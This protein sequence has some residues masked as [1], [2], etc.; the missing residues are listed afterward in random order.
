MD[1]EPG[2]PQVYQILILGHL[3]DDWSEWFGN[4]VVTRSADGVTTLT[5]LLADQSALHGVLN[6]LRDLGLPIISLA[7]IEAKR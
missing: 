4:L 7:R 5:G 1:S 2:H 3:D 6:K